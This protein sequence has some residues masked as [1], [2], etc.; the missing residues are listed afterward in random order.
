MEQDK[1]HQLQQN[2][3]ELGSLTNRVAEMQQQLRELETAVAGKHH[4]LGSLTS[5]VAEMQQ[6]LRELETAVAGKHHELGS[7]VS[8]VQLSMQQQQLSSARC[9][10]LQQHKQLAAG[11]LSTHGVM[12]GVKLAQKQRQ[13][14]LVARAL[15]KGQRRQAAQQLAVQ[16]L[17][18]Q[19]EEKQ[20]QLAETNEQLRSARAEELE[21]HMADGEAAAAKERARHL[22]P[23][24]CRQQH[25]IQGSNGFCLPVFWQSSGSCI[26]AGGLSGRFCGWALVWRFGLVVC[27]LHSSNEPNQWDAPRQHESGSGSRHASSCSINHLTVA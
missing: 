27:H 5:R 10:R 21:R 6:Q 24:E 23:G 2:E 20:G 25:E 16:Q 14:R 3:Q 12:A 9:Q 1:A 26:T 18:K 11:V 19:S 4:E 13:L 8:A 7:W 22:R 15:V 17:A